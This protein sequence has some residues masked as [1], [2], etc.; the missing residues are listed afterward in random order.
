MKIALNMNNST[1]T[2]KLGMIG[3][4]NV[5]VYKAF[6]SGLDWLVS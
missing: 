2:V 3:Q 5:Q 1:N 6:K 4:V